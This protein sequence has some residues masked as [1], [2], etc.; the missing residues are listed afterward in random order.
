MANPATA[1]AAS[2]TGDRPKRK[3]RLENATAAE[4]DRLVTE[5]SKWVTEVGGTLGLT[6]SASP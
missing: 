1:I 4:G 6:P 3:R 2:V 5:E